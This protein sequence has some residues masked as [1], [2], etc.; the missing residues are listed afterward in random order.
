MDFQES[1]GFTWRVSLAF[2]GLGLLMACVIPEVSLRT[3]LESKYGFE[4]TKA[5]GMQ[6]K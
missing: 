6:E 4:D 1:L 2:G 5:T 3:E